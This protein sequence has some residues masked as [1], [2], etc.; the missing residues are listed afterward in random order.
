MP[1]VAATMVSFTRRPSHPWAR[2][3]LPGRSARQDD[4]YG[5]RNVTGGLRVAVSAGYPRP[6]AVGFAS[7]VITAGSAH[8]EGGIHGVRT[9]LVFRSYA[10][11]ACQAARTALICSGSGYPVELRR[12]GRRG[13]GGLRHTPVLSLISCVWPG[14]DAVDRA[15]RAPAARA[16][17]GT[18]GP[19]QVSP[20]AA[21]CITRSRV[22]WLGPRGLGR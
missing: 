22:S 17:D 11:A 12:T 2:P 19:R 20:T 10:A 8:H 6:G 16:T 18:P 7:G 3:G 14:S 9:P 13:S 1:P 21:D 4:G 15:R 5:T